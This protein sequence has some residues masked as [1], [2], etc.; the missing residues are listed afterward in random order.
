MSD[1]RKFSQLRGLRP[2]KFN[3][4]PI[5]SGIT[6]RKEQ[7]RVDEIQKF[8]RYNSHRVASRRMVPTKVNHQTENI[9]TINGANVY[10]TIEHVLFN[11]TSRTAPISFLNNFNHCEPTETKTPWLPKTVHSNVSFD[12]FIRDTRIEQRTSFKDT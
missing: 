7:N 9:N 4:E 3:V 5:P 2:V 11:K 6:T 8:E 10:P 1:T 12:R